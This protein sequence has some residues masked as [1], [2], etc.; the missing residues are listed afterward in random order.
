MLQTPRPSAGLLCL[1]LLMALLP[2]RSAPAVPPAPPDY[3]PALPPSAVLDRA[4]NRPDKNS[5]GHGRNVAVYTGSPSR[6]FFATHELGD[7]FSAADGK[8]LA[9]YPDQ[10]IIEPRTEP[11]ASLVERRQVCV[12]EDDVVLARVHLTN[13]TNEPRTHRIEVAGDCRKSFDWR[14]KP[15]GEKVTRREGDVVLMLDKNVFPEFIKGGLAMVVGASVPPKEID[16][17][18][19]GTYRAAYEVEV[20]AGQTL[21]LSLACA[22]DVDANRAKANLARLLKQSHPAAENRKAWQRFYDEQVPRFECSDAGLNELYAFRWFLL[23]FSTAGGNLGLFEYPVVMEGRQ[24]FQTYCCYSAPFMAFDMNWATDPM[25]GFG[26]MATM[27]KVAYEDGRFP[28]YVSPRTNMVPLDHASRTGLS[29]LPW[30]AWRHYQTHGR[31]DLLEQL[32]PAMAKNVRWWIADRD[33]DGNGLF[34]ID[35]QL[36]TGMD[37]LH[38]RWKGG[39]APKRYEAVDATVYACLNLRSVANMARELGRAD[40]AKEFAEYA[41]RAAKALDTIAWDERTHAFRD[42]NPQTGELSDYTAITIFYPL[43]A[44]AAVKPEHL[45]LVREHLLNENEFWLPH[46]ISALSKSDPEFDPVKRY[47]AGPSWPAANSH[48]VE[49]FAS[50]AKR[51]DRSLLPQAAELFKRAARNHLQPRADFYER[52]DPFTG[53]P[54]SRFRDYMH[55]WWIDTIIRH[56]AGLTPQDDGSVMIDPLPMGLNFYA[57]RGAPHR[58][59]RVDVLFNDKEAG[60]GLTVRVDRKVV[61]RDENF[62]PGG[63]PVNVPAGEFR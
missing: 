30:T 41:D 29:L 28:W 61:R 58:G 63:E 12:T 44:E 9:W 1:A 4:G 11:P 39:A 22:I 62:K 6:F 42:R 49:G 40:D 23:K 38:R 26:H 60:R 50:T 18:T 19:P 10:V 24:A 56:V 13:T 25:V 2:S 8:T 27:A 21:S 35:H 14:N 33:P 32:Y 46:P 5:V 37:D 36:E 15:G 59:H 17:S 34:E 48:V 54:L 53:K 16:A 55:S 31:K 20:P 43:L 7:V 57:L 52:Y 3:L 47:W 51:L 45:A